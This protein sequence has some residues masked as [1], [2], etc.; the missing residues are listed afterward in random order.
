MLKRY[1]VFIL[2]PLGEEFLAVRAFLNRVSTIEDKQNR[3]VYTL[4]YYKGRRIALRECGKGQLAVA[5]AFIHGVHFLNPTFL[6]LVGTAG[7]VRKVQ[8]FDVVVGEKG[9]LYEAGRE[10]EGAFHTAPKESRASQELINKAKALAYSETWKANFEALSTKNKVLF[11][12]IAS[13][14]KVIQTTVGN[15]FKILQERFEDTIALEMEAFAFFDTAFKY[16]KLQVLNVRSISDMLSDKEQANLKG[17]KEIASRNAAFFALELI[18]TLPVER[19]LLPYIKFAAALVLVAF[20]IFFIQSRTSNISNNISALPTTIEGVSDSL[21]DEKG[22]NIIISPKIDTPRRKSE[23][24]NPVIPIV[25]PTEPEDIVVNST[26]TETTLKPHDE[27]L[28]ALSDTVIVK[29]VENDDNL[30][31]IIPPLKGKVHITVQDYQRKPLNAKIFLDDQE[32]VWAYANSGY[33]EI[34]AGKRKF[35]IAFEGKCYELTKEIK[36]NEKKYINL[37]IKDFIICP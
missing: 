15:T 6:L 3:E 4:G 1:D 11:G 29:R 25:N 36:E 24:E 13:G 33:L 31:P 34:A 30:P 5:T 27:S 37:K 12:P 18:K 35:R 16:P 26:A 22:E 28:E 20:F 23:S 9:Y 21:R 7:G 19:Q 32:N 14:E 2:C 10:L 17:S 8:L